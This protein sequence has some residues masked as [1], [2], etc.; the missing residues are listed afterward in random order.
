MYF[1]PRAGASGAWFDQHGSWNTVLLV[2]ARDA[3]GASQEGL[4]YVTIY[5]LVN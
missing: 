2:F 3:R 5:T 1:I 4:M